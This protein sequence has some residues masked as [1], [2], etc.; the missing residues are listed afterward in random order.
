VRTT[1]LYFPYFLSFSSTQE[2]EVLLQ[3]AYFR[4][5]SE[6]RGEANVLTAQGDRLGLTRVTKLLQVRVLGELYQVDCPQNG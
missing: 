6:D 4:V 2:R 1:E 3:Q 5:T